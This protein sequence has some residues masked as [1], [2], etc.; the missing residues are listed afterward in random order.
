[1]TPDFGAPQPADNQ[2]ASAKASRA[3]I[4]GGI[5]LPHAAFCDQIPAAGRVPMT[6]PDVSELRAQLDQILKTMADVDPSRLTVEEWRDFKAR[7]RDLETRLATLD[8]DPT[9]D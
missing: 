9:Q 5:K 6:T 2:P 7:V 3:V 1:M 8:A 4:A